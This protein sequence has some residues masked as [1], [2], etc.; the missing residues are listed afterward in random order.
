MAKVLDRFDSK[1]MPVTDCG[2]HLWTASVNKA[3]YG[4]FST[5]DGRWVLAHRA[6]YERVNGKL[7]NGILVC[8][9]C[10]TPAC[11]NPEHLFLGTYADNNRD[12]EAKNRGR[13]QCGEK[14]GRSKLNESNVIQLRELVQS[15]TMSAYAASKKFGIDSKTA[16]DIVSGKLWKHVA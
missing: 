2:C 12:R 15:G 8:H 10:D 1:W 3:G 13:Q 9:K 14:H 5:G 7:P 16:Y 4:K 11:V 6:A